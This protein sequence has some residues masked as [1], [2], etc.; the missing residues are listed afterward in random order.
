MRC[1]IE[2][3][4]SYMFIYYTLRFYFPCLS[5]LAQPVNINRL[6]YSWNDQY[7]FMFNF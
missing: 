4:Q 7:Y 5:L 2:F 1:H 3:M 6:L